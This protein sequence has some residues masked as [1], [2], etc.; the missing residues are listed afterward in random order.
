MS[1]SSRSIV[2]LID[3]MDAHALITFHGWR[4]TRYK[5]K[6]KHHRNGNIWWMDAF[7]KP[8]KDLDTTKEGGYIDR[9]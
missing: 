6:Q 1:S 8:L 5:D 7:D 9:Y 4:G 3:E 2:V